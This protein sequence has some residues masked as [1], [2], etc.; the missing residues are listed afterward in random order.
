[1]VL[2]LADQTFAILSQASGRRFSP[3]GIV[4]DRLMRSCAKL[5]RKPCAVI[6]R[7]SGD[8]SVGDEHEQH[9]GRQARQ[10]R[11]LAA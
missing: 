3:A 7:R 9:K 6:V 5:R 8:C 11:W 1:M 2:K 4:E 10:W